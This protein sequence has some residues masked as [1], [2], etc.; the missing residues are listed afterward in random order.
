MLTD[1][2]GPYRFAE[3]WRC[4]KPDMNVDVGRPESPTSALAALIG[5][6]A[7]PLIVDF[8]GEFLLAE[9]E[10]LQ[11]PPLIHSTRTNPEDGERMESQEY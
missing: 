5:R 10:I 3:S 8:N 1:G 11:L 2:H 9:V 6:V 7:F 4:G